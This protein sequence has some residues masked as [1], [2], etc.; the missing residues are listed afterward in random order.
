M[1][2]IAGAAGAAYWLL[3]RRPAAS[4]MAEAPGA[5]R[6]PSGTAAPAQP[7]PTPAIVDSARPDSARRD[8]VRPDSGPAAETTGLLL[9]SVEP[10]TA[11]IFVDGNSSGSGGFLNAEVKVGRR[12]IE[13]S[14]SGYQTLDTVVSVRP[15]ATVDLGRVSLM[16]E[17]AGRLRLRVSPPGAQIFVDDQQVGVGSLD[18]VEVPGGQRRLRIVAPGYQTL[19]TLISV[20]PGV[21]SLLGLISLNPGGR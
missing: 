19:D 11:E 12:Q 4:P 9:L 2:V 3:G 17:G 1:L 6:A 15:G 20:E 16:R 7:P 10:A 13:V 18:D 5:S 8:S 21:T 14:A